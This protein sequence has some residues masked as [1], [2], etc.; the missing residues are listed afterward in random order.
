MVY[1][2]H[3]NNPEIN[4]QSDLAAQFPIYLYLSSNKDYLLY[5]NSIQELLK[6]QEV[7]TPLELRE[8]SISF[9]LQSGIVPL[10]NIKIF[11]LWVLVTMQT[12]K[13]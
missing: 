8:E 4:I 9:L 5:S 3:S 1:K 6:H 10:P 11:S 2:Y 7:I 12:S 13:P